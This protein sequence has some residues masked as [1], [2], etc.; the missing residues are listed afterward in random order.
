MR[1]HMHEAGVEGGWDLGS[2]LG[3]YSEAGSET[4]TR[5]KTGLDKTR[6]IEHFS[7]F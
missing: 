1:M 4:Q 2:G 7:Y 3:C 6:L 5:G